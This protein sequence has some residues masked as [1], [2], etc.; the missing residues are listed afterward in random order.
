MDGYYVL[1]TRLGA[2]LF[3]YAIH[4]KHTAEEWAMELKFNQFSAER[5]SVGILESDCLNTDYNILSVNL[6]KLFNPEASFSHPLNMNKNGNFFL[7][8]LK[9]FTKCYL[10]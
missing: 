4:K 7:R 2:L 6:G 5:S 10:H 8:A 1:S 9:I 3:S